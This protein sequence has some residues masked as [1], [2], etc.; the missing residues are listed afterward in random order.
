MAR[1]RT[2]VPRSGRRGR[3][4]KSCHPDQY[5]RRPEAR[6]RN[7]EGLSCCGGPPKGTLRERRC[8][9]SAARKRPGP[10]SGRRGRRV[11]IL[12][13]RP[14][15]QVAD[16]RECRF[17]R[18]VF[19]SPAIATEASWEPMECPRHR[20]RQKNTQPPSTTQQTTPH[21]RVPSGHCDP[22]STTKRSFRAGVRQPGI[23]D[24]PKSQARPA[25]D[26][27]RAPPRRRSG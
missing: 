12:S 26:R 16:L 25:R 27:R 15:P 22:P 20:D 1:Q 23:T 11:Q 4:F 3:R 5:S 9:C 19:H 8:A 10:R 17:L 18:A 14:F 21:S 24:D 2:V 6:T 7:G 13:P